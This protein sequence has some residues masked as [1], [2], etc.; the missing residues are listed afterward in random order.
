MSFVE[1][2]T[3]KAVRKARQCDACF[4]MLA[5]GEAAVR[6]AGITDGEFATAVFHPDCRAAEIAVNRLHGTYP[7]EW[8]GLGRDLEWD[9]HQW[10][11][12]EYPTVAGRLGITQAKI[13]ETAAERERC[14]IAWSKVN[15]PSPEGNNHD[16][17]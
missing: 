8:M 15:R 7:D 9:D 17:G 10:L 11:L 3:I 16:P 12:D 4:Q 2:R 6:W 14:R 1:E 13:D 5:V